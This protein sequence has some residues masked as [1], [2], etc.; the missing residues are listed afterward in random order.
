MSQP[1]GRH[2]WDDVKAR[3][4][5]RS[6]VE[7]VV[8]VVRPYGVWLDLGIDFPGLMLLPE[9]GLEKGQE[10][11]DRYQPGQKVT[12]YVLWHNDEKQQVWL[13]LNKAFLA[14]QP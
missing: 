4:P 6:A 8:T 1:Q 12:A 2:T 13:T 14:G 10:P 5:V 9:A 11:C 3:L 7:G